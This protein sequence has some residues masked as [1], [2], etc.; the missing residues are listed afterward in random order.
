MYEEERRLCRSILCMFH[1]VTIFAF[2]KEK[3]FA[4]KAY[5]QGKS[6]GHVLSDLRST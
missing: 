2:W 5:T 4:S 6:V 1:A 3:G